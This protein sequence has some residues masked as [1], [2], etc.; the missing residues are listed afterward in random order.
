MNAKTQQ[1]T[2][3]SRLIRLPEVLRMTGLSRT[4]V[5]DRIREGKFPAPVS[6]GASAVAWVEIEVKAW[7]QAR[8]EAGRTIGNAA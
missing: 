4:G 8:I 6:L 7:I 5:Y 3:Q 1:Q 2:E